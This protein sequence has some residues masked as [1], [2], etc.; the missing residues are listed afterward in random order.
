M[1][2]F[3]NEKYGQIDFLYGTHPNEFLLSQIY[4]LTS[5]DRVLV[6]GDGEGRNGVW[7]A[8]QGF[9]V[10]TVDYSAIGCTKARQL[11]D[12]RGV[13]L[14]VHCADL[15]EWDWEEGGFDAVVLIYLHFE[16][17]SRREVYRRAAAALRPGGLLVIELFHPHQL[18]YQSGGPKRVD[19]LVRA[20]DL[21]QELTDIEWLLLAEGKVLLDEGPG[22]Q[23]PGFVTHGVGRRAN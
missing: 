23:G 11:A 1:S 22:H 5:G 15:S 20:S 19:M 14:A 16:P 4:R 21:S 17:S 10:T 2:E 12:E 18:A 3:W 13:S 9:D 7:L 6:L 8:E